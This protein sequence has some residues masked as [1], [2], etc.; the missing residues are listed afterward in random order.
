LAPS[1]DRA[2]LLVIL[3]LVPQFVFA[4]GMVPVSDLGTAGQVLGLVT[5]TR[6]ELGALA[7]SAHVRS[8]SCDSELTPELTDCLLPGLLGKESAGERQAL[9]KSLD[10]KYGDIFAV[11]VYFNWGMAMVLASALLGATFLLQKRKDIL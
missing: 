2:M 4:G 11:N 1:E 9:L 10:D 6:W 8:G 5:S 7:T 3:V